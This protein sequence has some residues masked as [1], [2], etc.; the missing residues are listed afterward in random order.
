MKK[1][2][3]G[4]HRV[5]LLDE[6]PKVK[7]FMYRVSIL[8]SGNTND[9]PRRSRLVL[10]EDGFPLRRAHELHSTIAGTGRGAYSHWESQILFS[11][12][13]NSDPNRNGRIYSYAI[14]HGGHHEEEGDGMVSLHSPFHRHNG[15]CW[16]A[17]VS[18]L[19][20]HVSAPNI[21]QLR[22]LEDG[23]PIGPPHTNHDTIAETGSGAYSHWDN[24]LY[25]STSDNSDP[26]TNGRLYSYEIDD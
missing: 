5:T 12:S 8:L 18:E 16:G 13:D 14:D 26:N 24:Y 17:A 22:L 2:F 23:R 15:L 1:P 4:L 21:S 11:T 25:F 3:L 9:Q 19:G 7:G 10:F 6:F 20:D